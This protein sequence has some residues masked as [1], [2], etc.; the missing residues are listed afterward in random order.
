V[1]ARLDAI[2]GVAGARAE[3]TGRHLLLELAPETDLAAVEAAARQVLGGGARRLD[4]RAAAAQLEAIS[5]GDRWFTAAEAPQLSFL[6]A[7]ILS[8]R[9]AGDLVGALA[10]PAPEAARLVEAIRQ[11]LFEAVERVH[12]EGGR[13]SSGWFFAAWPE[14]AGRIAGQ[15]P[16]GLPPASREAL[17]AALR[18]QFAR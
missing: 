11:V 9:I 17:D 18:S 3:G 10:L 13:E 8:V 7:R 16:A 2:P 12:A 6:E 5:R 4:E 14:L 15:F 1:L